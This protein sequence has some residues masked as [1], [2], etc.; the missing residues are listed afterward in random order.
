MKR[1]SE[2]SR[3]GGRKEEKEEG[4]EGQKE[5]KRLKNIGVMVLEVCS[6]TSGKEY[7]PYNFFFFKKRKLKETKSTT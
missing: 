5:E 6:K 1:G 4:K 7:T 3:K 2:G